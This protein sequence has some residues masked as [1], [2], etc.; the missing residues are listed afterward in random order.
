MN[1]QKIVKKLLKKA[2]EVEKVE[3]NPQNITEIPLELFYE[4]YNKEK[5]DL[6]YN[7][8]KIYLN[9]PEGWKMTKI[10]IDLKEIELK[11]GYLEQDVMELKKW[12]HEVIDYINEGFKEIRMEINKLKKKK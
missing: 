5:S 12:T 8:N 4:A 1:N 6:W 3:I 10:G 2:K 11:I 7:S 9:S